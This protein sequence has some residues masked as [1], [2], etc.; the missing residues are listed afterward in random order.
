M[1]ERIGEEI[2]KC[3]ECKMFKDHLDQNK[4]PHGQIHTTEV[5]QLICTDLAE[6]PRSKSG[7]KYFMV[8]VDHYSKWAQAYALKDKEA[9]SIACVCIK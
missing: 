5:F 4:A 3:L 1:S 8:I 2:K 6:M 9:S 7:H